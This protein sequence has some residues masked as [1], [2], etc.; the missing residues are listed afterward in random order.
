MKAHGICPKCKSRLIYRVPAVS[1]GQLPSETIGIKHSISGYQDIS[2]QAFICKKCG[3]VEFY[4][5]DSK[6]GDLK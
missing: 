4:V 6:L 1:G 2:F 5:P 3:Y